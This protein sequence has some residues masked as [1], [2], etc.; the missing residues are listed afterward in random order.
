MQEGREEK[1]KGK[2]GIMR[3]GNKRKNVDKEGR[4]QVNKRKGC[5]TEG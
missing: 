5:V 3:E 1:T 4:R 2:K